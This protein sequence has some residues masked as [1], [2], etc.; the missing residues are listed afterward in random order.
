MGNCP[1]L[2]TFKVVSKIC[3][4]VHVLLHGFSRVF[5]SLYK[6][7]RNIII[8]IKGFYNSKK[9]T[10]NGSQPDARDYYWYVHVWHVYL[11]DL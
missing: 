5:H 2:K 8:G 1:D 4:H 6:V 9:V 11:G 10:P 3:V 7:G